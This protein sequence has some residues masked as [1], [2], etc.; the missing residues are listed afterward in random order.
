MA[1][2]VEAANVSPSNHR[3]DLGGGGG[4]LKYQ[5]SRS[6]VH[7]VFKLHVEWG[8]AKLLALCGT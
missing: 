4:G 3:T 8:F 2:S 6:E 1:Q 5:I 7:I